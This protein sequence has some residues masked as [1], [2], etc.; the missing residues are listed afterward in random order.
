MGIFD[1][2][3]LSPTIDPLAVYFHSYESF[4]PIKHRYSKSD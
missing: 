2:F 3:P 1:I 4:E